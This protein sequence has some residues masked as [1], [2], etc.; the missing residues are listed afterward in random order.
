MLYRI[1]GFVGFR[2]VI[3]MFLGGG[4]DEN[5]R[6]KYQAVEGELGEGSY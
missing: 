2:S 1:E 5:L 4:H 6:G 3:Q